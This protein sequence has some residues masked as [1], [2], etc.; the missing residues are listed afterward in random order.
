M[1]EKRKVLLVGAECA[2][3]AKT[4]G[5]AD[6]IGTLPAE[7]KKQGVDARVMIPLHAKI[8]EKYRYELEHLCTFYVTL[9]WRTQFCGIETLTVDGVQYYFV[10][11]EFY[12]GGPIYKG[13]D[14]E[15]EQYA[16]FTRVVLEALP[17]IDFIPDVIHVNDWH[18][19]MIPMLL[20]TQYDGALK[21]IKTVFTIHNIA[22]QG[23]FSFG[24]VKD[25]LGIP[26]W[27]LTPEYMEAYGC[28]NFLKAGVVFA[29][30]VNTV[31]PSYAK[32]LK[33]PYFSEGMDGIL[34]ARGEDFTGIINGINVV[35]FDPHNDKRIA[36]KYMQGSL[37]N[38]K[39]NKLALINELGLE[40][41]EDTPVLSMI[42]RL[43]EQKGID[44]LILAIDKIMA[45]GACLV[46][47]GS[48]D[49]KYEDFFRNAENKYPGR[50]SFTSKYDEDLSHRIYAGSDIFLM[51]SKF[52]PCGI[53]QMLAMR[54]GTPPV[55]RETGGLKDTVIPYNAFTNEGTGFS[56]SNY[57]GDEM[58]TAIKYALEVFADK[59]AFRSLQKQAMS[60]DFSFAASASK[61]IELYESCFAK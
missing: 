58:M 2:P 46:V 49:K 55:V 51:P 6:V 19:A 22:Y 20:K 5:L 60:M 27:F 16:F 26:D 43:T 47:L 48:G 42:S 29:D 40:A 57:N 15:G 36:K 50:L 25:L 21:D 34:E 37:Y 11:N 44:L 3:F 17:L 59:K 52:E 33:F 23:K 53:S 39:H 14:E 8:K 45:T 4:G 10:D 54:Y 13:G 31:S 35:D 12:F 38:K 9:G 56:F 24:F 61:Y 1:S 32:E 30:K 7:L 28:A 41:N 18:T